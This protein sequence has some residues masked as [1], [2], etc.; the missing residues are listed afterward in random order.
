M[1]WCVE[2]RA[3]GQVYIGYVSGHSGLTGPQEALETS[4]TVIPGWLDAGAGL[5]SDMGSAAEGALV[6]A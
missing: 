2:Q 1:Y 3:W 5:L 4:M 6:G